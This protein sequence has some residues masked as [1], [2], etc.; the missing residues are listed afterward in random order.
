MRLAV[1]NSEQRFAAI[2]SSLRLTALSLEAL[3]AFCRATPDIDRSTFRRF[4]KPL[5]AGD[6]A[7]EALEWRP[8]VAAP[9]EA[10]VPPFRSS[11]SPQA[12]ARSASR[13]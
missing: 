10:P 8:Q 5:L 7:I 3:D 13:P 4:V 6:P 2:E 11:T 1:L 9:P 12:S